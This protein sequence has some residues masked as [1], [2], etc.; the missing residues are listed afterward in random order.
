MS[1]E[2]LDEALVELEEARKSA[3]RELEG[4]KHH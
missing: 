3:Q 4:I 2:D 1:D